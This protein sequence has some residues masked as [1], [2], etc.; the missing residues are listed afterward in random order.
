MNFEAV[1]AWYTE[2]VR[3]RIRNCGL[4]GVFGIILMPFAL[5]LAVTLIF[6]V[7]HGFGHRR[8][9]SMSVSTAV[10]I[11]LAVIP[12]MF[13]GNRFTPRQSLLD[14]WAGDGPPDSLGE[15]YKRRAEVY[16]AVILW[17][18]FAG[19]RLID[20]SIDSFRER[21]RLKNL[22]V[23]SCS[24]VLWLL[25][26]RYKKVPYEDI[27]TAIPWLDMEATIPHVMAIPGVVTL[28]THPQGLSLTQDMRDMMRAGNYD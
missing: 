9:E 12:L 2:S 6:A 25:L 3:R 5:T 20:W 17:I 10:W 11:S 28:N 1:K 4:A 14:K 24:A 15:R 16:V 7:L 18:L 27:Q 13:I 19:P 23:H 22:D 21:T 8:E 26:S